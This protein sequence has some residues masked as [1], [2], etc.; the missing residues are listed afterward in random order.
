MGILGRIEG[1]EPA[2]AQLTAAVASGRLAHA[3]LFAGP[4]GTGRLTAALELAASRVCRRVGLGYCGECR[5]CTR[6]FEFR[7]PDVNVTVPVTGRTEPDDIAALFA[8]RIADGVTPLTLGGSASITIDQ[9]RELVR[10]LSVRSF[11]GTG[12]VEIVTD[13]HRM[14]MEAANALLK[15]LE[16]PPDDTVIVLV[17]S[18]VSAL[19]STIRSRAHTVRF[20]R[21]PTETVASILARRAGIGPEEAMEIALAS[22]GRP[23]QALLAWSARSGGKEAEDPVAAL[24]A[25]AACSK[26]SA[27][28]SIAQGFVRSPDRDRV[29]ALVQGFRTCLHDVVRVSMGLPP[30]THVPAALDRLEGLAGAA[31]ASDGLF[32][33][34]EESLRMNGGLLVVLASALLGF[35]REAGHGSASAEGTAAS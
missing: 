14:G 18:S 15:T 22:D 4:S 2:D 6:V 8:A 27:V 16:E 29:L 10:R 24:K 7:H 26:A 13:A 3:Y 12:H 21:L 17:T 35:W 20:R 19:L 31:A 9:V 5:D 1:Q 23:G 28:V 25:V 33:R 32:A 11:E 30:L 34:A